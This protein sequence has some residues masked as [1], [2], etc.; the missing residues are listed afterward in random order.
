MLDKELLAQQQS[1]GVTVKTTYFEKGFCYLRKRNK[2]TMAKAQNCHVISK[3][4]TYLPSP[5]RFVI[6]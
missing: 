5:Y 2:M 6:I 4:I 3:Q 1:F